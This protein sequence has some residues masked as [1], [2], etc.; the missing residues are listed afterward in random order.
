MRE[1]MGIGAHNIA[2]YSTIY[3]TSMSTR[4]CWKNGD[5][6][7]ARCKDIKVKN[8]TA[9]ALPFWRITLLSNSPSLLLT[10]ELTEVSN[11]NI[12]NQENFYKIYNK[13]WAIP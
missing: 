11:E 9:P 5:C 12:F 3:E 1:D 7:G 13:T 8:Q 2:L 4:A 6:A 10:R